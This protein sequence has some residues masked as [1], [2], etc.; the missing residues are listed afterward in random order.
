MAKTNANSALNLEHLALIQQAIQAAGAAKDITVSTETTTTG[1]LRSYTFKKGGNDL[2]VIDIP[3][4]YINNI[5]GFVSEDGSG[6][7]G[8][9]LKVKTNAIGETETYDYIDASGLV[10]YLTLGD[11]TGKPVQL[12]ISQDHKI[13]G[14]LADGSVAKAKLVTAVQ[15]TL[16][17][18]DTAYGWGNHAE[19]GY[20]V[21][22]FATDAEVRTVLGLP[23]GE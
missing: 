16:T 11:Q 15:T 6:N 8:V 14:D 9:F 20:I 22:E 17:N 21:G 18:A 10:E 13:T 7:E 2:V 1:M 23:A 5:V 3:K 19:A 4:D 12:T